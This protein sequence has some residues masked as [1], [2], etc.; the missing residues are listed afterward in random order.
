MNREIWQS[1]QKQEL[2]Y[3]TLTR[4]KKKLT[5]KNTLFDQKQAHRTTWTAKVWP[6][7]HHHHDGTIR[8]N[9]YRSQ[10]DYI[11]AK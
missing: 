4:K 11:I 7:E 8:K 10:K 5:L 1:D 2:L 9:L 6:N 3:F